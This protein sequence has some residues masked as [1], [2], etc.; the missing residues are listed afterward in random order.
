[1]LHEMWGK[2]VAH[3]NDNSKFTNEDLLFAIIIKHFLI[4]FLPTFSSQQS[5]KVSG[6]F[7]INHSHFISEETVT[8]VDLHNAH[9]WNTPGL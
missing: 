4:H 7:V 9:K 3:L 1:M 5:C 2:L 6:G 8:T